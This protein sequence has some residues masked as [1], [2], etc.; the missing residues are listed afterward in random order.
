MTSRIWTKVVERESLRLG[1]GG[2]AA[3]IKQYREA[4]LVG[5]DGAVVQKK[6]ISLTNT[7]PAFGHPSSAEEGSSIRKNP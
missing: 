2:V 7:T 5:A 3:P 1:Q 6:Q 4:S